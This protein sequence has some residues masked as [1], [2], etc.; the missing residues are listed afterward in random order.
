[1]TRAPA[2]LPDGSDWVGRRVRYVGHST[3]FQEEGTVVR[4]AAT[5]NLAMFV[6]YD[7]VEDPKLT[8]ASDL[9]KI[10]ELFDGYEDL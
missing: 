7:N 10:P 1:M 5:R 9:V 2:K 6:K 3:A 8:Y 4:M